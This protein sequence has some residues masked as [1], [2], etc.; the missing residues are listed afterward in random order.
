[1]KVAIPSDE[2]SERSKVSEHFERCKFF[3]IFT[4]KNGNIVG[5]DVMANPYYGYHEPNI[6]PQFIS[7]YADVVI[8]ENIGNKAVQEFD[9]LNTKVISGESGVISEVIKRYLVKLE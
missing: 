3:I 6:I 2:N 7:K 4:M 5:K 9:R 1:M 8:V